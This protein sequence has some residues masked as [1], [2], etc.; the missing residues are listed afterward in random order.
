MGVE[1][2]DLSNIDLRD[3]ITLDEVIKILEI[4]NKLLV[5]SMVNSTR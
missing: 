2:K 1:D 3:E 4:K 5:I